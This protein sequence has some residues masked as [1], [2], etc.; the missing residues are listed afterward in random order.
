M[1]LGMLLIVGEESLTPINSGQL[2]LQGEDFG[3]ASTCCTMLSGG[4][5]EVC[6]FLNGDRGGVDGGG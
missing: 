6:P 3:S 1:V 5:W 2:S 4:P